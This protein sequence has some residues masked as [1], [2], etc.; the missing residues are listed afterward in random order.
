M[1]IKTRSFID[2]MAIGGFAMTLAVS[3]IDRAQAASITLF[4]TGV[5]NLG[6]VQADGASESHYTLTSVP[7]GTTNLI[8]RTAVGGYP[9]PPWIGDNSTSAW[10]GP[11]NDAALNSAPGSYTFRTTFSLDGLDKD[12]ATISGRWSTDNSGLQILLNNV[13]IG[14][15]N[16]GFTSFSAFNIASGSNFLAGANTLDFIVSNAQNSPG[17]NTANPIGLRVELSG[18]AAA[19]VPEPSD[20]IG[21]VLAFGSV[22]LLKRRLTTKAQHQD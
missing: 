2:G 20:L 5:D 1:N 22:V 7:S 17:D 11:S 12:T 14:S 21:T 3:P 4:N 10:I 9:I 15:T 8:A 19:A 16:G 18:I 13:N 6:N